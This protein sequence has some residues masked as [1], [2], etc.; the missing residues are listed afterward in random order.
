MGEYKF[1]H[2]PIV[3]WGRSQNFGENKTCISDDN[4][5]T[6]AN[7][8]ICP[9]GY[10]SVYSQMLGHNGIDIPCKRWTPLYAPVDGFIEETSTE[11]AR[12]LGIGLVTSRKYLCKETGEME[13][14]KVRMW[15]LISLYCRK[16][17]T[18]KQG[19]LIGWC[20]STGY[21]TGDHLHLELK[22]VFQMKTGSDWQ[23]SLPNNG[24]FGAVD[25]DTY[26]TGIFVRNT[27]GVGDKV[28]EGLA[29][30]ADRIADALRKINAPIY[31]ER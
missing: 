6:M 7:P 8:G 29:Q 31:K 11:A 2:N 9:P 23:H 1:L 18:V 12:G 3:N 16:G 24:Y 22:P 20:D 13:Y 14:F 19:Q 4:K 21:S 15:H 27:I 25:P 26:W 30:M 5:K 10:R 28:L 17:D